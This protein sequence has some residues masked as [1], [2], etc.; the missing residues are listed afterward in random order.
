LFVRGAVHTLIRHF[1][2]P[3]AELRVEIAQTTRFAALQSTQEISAYILYA[4]FHLALSLRAIR[5]AQPGRESPVPREIQKHRMPN[6]FTALV[7]L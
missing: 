4:R 1:P 5:S 2:Y 7:D 6:H 3:R